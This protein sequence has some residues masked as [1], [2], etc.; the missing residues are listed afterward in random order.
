MPQP[1]PSFV[2]RCR[3]GV[4]EVAAWR[5][6]IAV[7]ACYC[8]DCQAAAR[9]LAALPGATSIAT[10]DGGTEFMLFRRDAFACTAGA[11]RLRAVRLTEGSKSRRMVT[12]CCATPMYLAFDDGRPWVSAFRA[13]FGGGAPP[14][15]ARICTKSRR[16]AEPLDDSAPAYA[17]Y[18]PAMMVRLLGAGL[19]MLFSRK[20]AGALP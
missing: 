12:N 6:P 4:V 1:N 13:N 10:A 15:E 8:E 9:Q 7:N 16:A 3:C 2:A 20:S 19:G 5:A 18:P 11:E 14:V 17:S